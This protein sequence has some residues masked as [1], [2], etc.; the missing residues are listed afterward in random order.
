MNRSVFVVTG[1]WIVDV[2]RTR[3]TGQ[4]SALRDPGSRST[5][6][7]Q[8]GGLLAGG[9]LEKLT[10]AFLGDPHEL[11]Q[12]LDGIAALRDLRHGDFGQD[13]HPA[14]REAAAAGGQ[15][16]RPVG[17]GWPDDGGQA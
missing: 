11:G 12:I 5:E 4:S 10:V 8:R 13:Q 3:Q 14:G 1:R 7:G 2:G 16:V 17:P 6:R 15:R 9:A